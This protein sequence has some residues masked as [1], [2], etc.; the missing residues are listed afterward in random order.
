MPEVHQHWL[1]PA[2]T[3]RC[4]SIPQHGKTQELAREQQLHWRPTRLIKKTGADED[5]LHTHPCILL[6][7]LQPRQGKEDHKTT[8]FLPSAEQQDLSKMGN[9]SCPTVAILLELWQSV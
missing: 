7:L 8:H 1:L 3:Q 2:G 9:V 6:V 5:M 4:Q